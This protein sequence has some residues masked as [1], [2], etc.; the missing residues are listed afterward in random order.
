MHRINLLP[1]AAIQRF[2]QQRL[3]SVWRKVILLAT[4]TTATAIVW[5]QS[6]AAQN[7]RGE[8]MQT[9]IAQ[10]PRQIRKEC[11]ELKTQL[12]ELQAYEAQQRNAR[13]QHSPLV[14]IEM[15][16]QLKQE[17]AGQLQVKSFGFS[18]QAATPAAG[19]ASTISG[20][21]DLQLISPGS[22][23]CSRV[24]HLLRETGY[25]SEVSLS[26]SLEKVDA[27]SD[28]LQYSLRCDF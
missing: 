11:G 15:L 6:R 14:A 1:P 19:T 2:R 9:A 23:S 13:G 25:F 24:M 12:R 7:L 4:L 8:E 5:G 28:A 17:L 10:H 22:A 3:W 20:H 16:H 27:G 18:D 26:S 21:V